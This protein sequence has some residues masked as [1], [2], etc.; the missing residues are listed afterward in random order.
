M[1]IECS[2]SIRSDWD[3]FASFTKLSSTILVWYWALQILLL[4]T[5][6]IIFFYIFNIRRWYELPELPI[7][8]KFCSATAVPSK[9]FVVTCHAPADGT[10]NNRVYL[11]SG[12]T[13]GSGSQNWQWTELP[14]MTI[15]ALNGTITY[16]NGSVY[17]AT[18]KRLQQ[19]RISM[20]AKTEYTWNPETELHGD[21]SW[22]SEL[23]VF[24]NRL[25]IH[26]A[27]ILMTSIV[28]IKRED[29]NLKKINC[30]LS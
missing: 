27:S 9:G 11:L 28:L 14:M 26:G 5:I 1:V 10:I 20:G 3:H 24:N 8:A 13:D 4:L 18:N 19:L 25:F 15:P 12:R 21:F 17:A 7:R 6:R 2:L 16:L 30:G 22:A 23:F 29:F